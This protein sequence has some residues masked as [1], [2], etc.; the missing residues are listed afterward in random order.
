MGVI[1]VALTLEERRARKRRHY[2]ANKDRILA[3][4]KEYRDAN[5]DRTQARHKRYYADNTDKRR[6]AAREHHEKNTDLARAID[7]RYYNANRERIN[8]KRSAGRLHVSAWYVRAL[9]RTYKQ[10]FPPELVAAKKLQLQ[11][12]RKLKGA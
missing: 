1:D 11:I 2:V 6:S 7:L 12:Y 9:F 8:A 5:K 4:Q 10:E 3:A